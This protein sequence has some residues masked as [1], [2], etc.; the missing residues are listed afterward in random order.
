MYLKAPG[1]RFSFLGKHFENGIYGNALQ[2]G[3][4]WQRSFSVFEQNTCVFRL[5]QISVEGV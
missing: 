5:I 3:R 4:F 2:T 1:L